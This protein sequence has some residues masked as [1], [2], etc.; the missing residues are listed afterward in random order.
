MRIDGNQAARTLRESGTSGRPTAASGVLSNVMSNVMSSV[1]SSVLSGDARSS[2]SRPLGRSLGEDQARFSGARWQVQALRERALQFP[3]IRQ[4]KVD[5][6]RAA[7]LG[8]NYQIDSKQLADAM[9][10]HL[11]TPAA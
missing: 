5:A 10:S 3:E 8:G 1:L 4:E 2:T 6:L 9:F 7:V 11:I